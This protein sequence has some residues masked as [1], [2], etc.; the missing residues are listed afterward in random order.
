MKPMA[1]NGERLTG[2]QSAI[3]LW[4]PRPMA[5]VLGWPERR[6]A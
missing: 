5:G 1:Q 3:A 4:Q 2:E 6:F